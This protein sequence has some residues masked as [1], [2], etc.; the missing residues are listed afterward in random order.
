MEIANLEN[1]KSQIN[2]KFQD[3]GKQIAD[4]QVEQHRL[5]G[6]YNLCEELI[7][8]LQAVGVQAGKEKNAKPTT[9]TLRSK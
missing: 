5:A 8:E 2:T 3:I 9:P 4:L 6:A 7:K 1:R